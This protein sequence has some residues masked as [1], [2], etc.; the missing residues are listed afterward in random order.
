MAAYLGFVVYAAQAHPY[1]FAP[2]GGGY[3]ASER[4]LA[5]ARR[6]VEAYDGA[7]EVTAL[8]DYGQ[9][10]QYSLLHLDD[11]V[12]VAVE[13]ELSLVNVDIVFAV[14]APR[15]GEHRLQIVEQHLVVGAL[16]V[17][18]LQLVNLPGQRLA[19]G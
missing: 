14:F 18:V 13:G 8:L 10:L 16:G 11:A 7:L 15:H 19:C 3:A 9:V 5:Y 2:H 1:V 17:D 6:T 4:C 12:V